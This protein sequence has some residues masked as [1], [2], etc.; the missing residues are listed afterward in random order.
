MSPQ[1]GANA[2]YYF[3]SWS[4]VFRIDVMQSVDP[5]VRIINHDGIIGST[6]QGF[7][8][9]LASVAKK[10]DD[11]SRALLSGRQERPEGSHHRR[12]RRTRVSWLPCTS[13]PA[14]SPASSSTRP[15]SP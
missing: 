13:G 8:G 3:K 2:K 4:P 10:F 1:H 6:L 12:R 14:T 15:R 11:D 5:T 9:N 7:D